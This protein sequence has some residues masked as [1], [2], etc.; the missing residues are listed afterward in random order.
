MKKGMEK[1]E[2]LLSLGGIKKD[3]VLLVL[4]GA[5]VIAGLCQFQPFP[6]DIA[7]VVLSKRM[8]ATIKPNMTFLMALNFVVIALVIGGT[9]NPVVGALIHNARPVLVITTSAFLLKW[10][11]K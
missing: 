2:W 8:M 9:I 4:S 10:R 7:W 6:F 5:V 1:L 11:K 3:V